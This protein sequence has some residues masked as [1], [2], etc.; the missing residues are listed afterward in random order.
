MDITLGKGNCPVCGTEI[1]VMEPEPE[2]KIIEPGN[3]IVICAK[4]LKV[5]EFIFDTGKIV[6]LS[7]F[8]YWN[9]SEEDRL[10]IQGMRQIVYEEKNKPK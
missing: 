10:H 3:R 1:F 2:N 8:A 4:C 9:L 5:L 6:A 7:T